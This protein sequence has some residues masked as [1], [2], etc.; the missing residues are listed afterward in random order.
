MSR[1]KLVLRWTAAAVLM[2][3]LVIGGLQAFAVNND[4]LFEMGSDAANPGGVDGLL[5]ANIA[6][7]GL[8]ANGPDW[9]DLFNSDGSEKDSNGNGNPDWKEIY[10]GSA[11]AFLADDLS[12]QSSVDRTTFAGSNKN[13][14]LISTWNWDTGNS[15]SKDDITNAYAYAKFENGH[16]IVYGGV[17]RRANN[18]DSHIDLEFNQ[19]EIGLDKGIPCGS[20]G[21][22]AGDGSPCEFVNEKTV[23]D[24][25]VSLDFSQGGALGSLSVHKWDGTD[26]ILVGEVASEGCNAA[27]NGHPADVIC[28]FANNSTINDAGGWT[29]YTN[30]G[31]PTS[32]LLTNAF[33]EFGV[34]VTDLLGQ[35]PCLAS[36]NVHTRSSQSFTAELKDFA[37][38]SFPLCSIDVAKSPNPTQICEGVNTSVTYT[39]VVTNTGSAPLT[40]NLDDDVLGHIAGPLLLAANASQ[41][42]TTSTNISV[43]T[44]NVVT[45]TGTNGNTLVTATAN[46]TVNAINC[47][48][49][50]TKFKD[51]NSDRTKGAGEPGLASWQFQLKSGNTVLQTATTDA[52]G[53]YTFTNVAPGT[54]TVHELGQTGWRQTTPCTGTPCLGTDATVVVDTDGDPTIAPPF[55]NTPLSDISVTFS[56][57]TSPPSTRATRIRCVD[58]QGA[59]VSD[60]LNNNTLSAQ[61]VE[62]YQSPIVCTITY[63]DP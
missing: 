11:A 9:K 45:A 8:V 62:V 37:L 35:T 50:G 58:S 27:F 60:V 53:N 22:P 34:D 20:D 15:P 63:E 39:Y 16:L 25:I 26:Y 5:N 47:E 28:A 57:Q 10:G 17:E 14:D 42:F 33:S 1:R 49:H 48:I 7:D 18:G 51:I 41:T 23:G 2:L 6:G 43:T 19:Q 32:Q 21:V 30:N 36:I 3:G 29:H 12:S 46:A 38:H 56:P 54:Y 4:N 55:G 31:Q 59:V 44:T 24:F 13:N 52:S 61:G 40:V